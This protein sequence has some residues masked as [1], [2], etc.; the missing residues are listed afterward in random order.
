MVRNG[1]AALYVTWIVVMICSVVLQGLYF[2]ARD[3]VTPNLP[4]SFYVSD[5]AWAAAMLSV[6][7]IGRLP[8]LTLVMG[9]A[10]FVVIAIDL[11]PTTYDHSV[12]WFLWRHCLMLTYLVAAHVAAYLRLRVRWRPEV[13]EGA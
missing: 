2:F 8:I 4:H 10:S 11:E 6:V 13:V 3:A 7:F 12:S 1:G 5:W 9:W